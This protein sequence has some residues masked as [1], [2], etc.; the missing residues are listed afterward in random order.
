LRARGVKVC[1]VT[2]GPADLETMGVN[3]MNPGPRVDVLNLARDTATVQLRRQLDAPDGWG[4][5]RLGIAR[6]GSA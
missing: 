2:P 4:Q 1:I 5:G 6:G 3:L